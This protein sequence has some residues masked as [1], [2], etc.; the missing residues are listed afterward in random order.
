MFLQ[1]QLDH[2]VLDDLATLNGPVPQPAEP[3]LHTGETT[4]KLRVAM[5]SSARA[6]RTIV[7]R[8]SVHTGQV[9]D[10]I[11]EELK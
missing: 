10:H 5:A 11:S 4:L 8:I 9:L 3:I 2:L 1:V 7:S 6:V